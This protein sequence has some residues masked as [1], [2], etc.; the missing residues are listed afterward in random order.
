MITLFTAKTGN[1]YRASILLEECGLPYQVKA[2]GFTGDLKTPEFLAIN[3]IG[4][5]PAIVDDD[6]PDGEKVAIGES[7]AIAL[8]LVEKAGGHLLPAAA[9]DRARAAMW[10]SAIVTGF[11]S[12]ISGIFFARAIDAEAHA[13][14]IAKYFGDI[15]LHLTAMDRAL[16]E[17]PYLGGPDYSWADALAAPLILS[18]LPN[19]AVDLTPFSNILRWRDTVAAR[20]AVMAG[21]AVPN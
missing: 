3:P 16:G 7:L 2:M 15:N 9:A 20:P 13:G 18:T 21:M 8:Y 10:A 6:G 11:A 4:K 5:I 14:I 17:R 19:F 12:P 1:G